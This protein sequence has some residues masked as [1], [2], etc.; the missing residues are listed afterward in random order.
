MA[1]AL[2]NGLLVVDGETAAL[3]DTP[4]K[5]GQTGVLWDWVKNHLLLTR[6][7]PLTLLQ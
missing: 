4:W 1:F 7:T 2:A 3:I 5:N 6:V